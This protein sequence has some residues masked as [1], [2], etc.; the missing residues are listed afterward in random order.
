VPKFSPKQ[1]KII[2]IY[3][4]YVASGISIQKDNLLRKSL[5]RNEYIDVK[6]EL[7]RL[8]KR[9]CV[10]VDLRATNHFTSKETVV[11]GVKLYLDRI[12]LEILS[13]ELKIFGGFY[14]E[15]VKEA[16][17]CS[18][19]YEHHLQAYLENKKSMGTV[20]D[21]PSIICSSI[22]NEIN[23]PEAIARSVAVKNMAVLPILCRISKGV[24]QP[25]KY[26]ETSKNKKALNMFTFHET[27]QFDRYWWLKL[28][29]SLNN[30]SP[31]YVYKM[32]VVINKSTEY[33]VATSKELEN[34]NNLACFFQYGLTYGT[35]KVFQI[36][37]H[38]FIKTDVDK[39]YSSYRLNKNQNPGLISHC[40]YIKEVSDYLEAKVCLDFHVKKDTFINFKK[41]HYLPSHSYSVKALKK[42]TCLREYERYVYETPATI[43]NYILDRRP[44]KLLDYSLLGAK[45]KIP[46]RPQK[47]KSTVRLSIPA[48]N[49]I[50]TSITGIKYDVVDYSSK[51]GVA[52]LEVSKEYKDR[53]LLMKNILDNNEHLLKDYSTSH[54]NEVHYSLFSE[55]V[56]E[57]NPVDLLFMKKSGTFINSIKHCLSAEKEQKLCKLVNDKYH[58]D[59]LISKPKVKL[60]L[61]KLVKQR[62]EM[63][64]E[65]IYNK[66]ENKMVINVNKTLDRKYAISAKDDGAV[67]I[68]HNCELDV[69][70]TPL[71][72][73]VKPEITTEQMAEY[74]DKVISETTGMTCLELFDTTNVSVQVGLIN[75]D[76]DAIKRA[77]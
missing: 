74:Y 63:N 69:R 7:V 50:K 21:C 67:F 66:I 34:D 10:G 54:I 29:E 37:A 36:E 6:K 52:R 16:L 28:N 32:E 76:G 2:S 46:N 57:G 61:T 55:M 77:A 15:G 8:N 26:L 51:T 19:K 45:I 31:V 17:E 56:L 73:N 41:Y 30:N 59:G 4:H 60:L 13:K 11:Q 20:I 3:K 43:N 70:I 68:R 64:Q 72:R 62:K 42:E 49:N 35:V 5:E 25:I 23:S 9:S 47:L 71:N 18:K 75:S 44:V 14:T 12:S 1:I 39:L 33:Y 40:V 38:E 48:F 24:L 53:M 27:V 58:L 22:S 65:F